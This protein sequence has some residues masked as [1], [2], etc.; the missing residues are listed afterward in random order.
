M[1]MYIVMH[2]Y[3]HLHVYENNQSLSPGERENW[4]TCR[5]NTILTIIHIHAQTHIRMHTHSSVQYLLCSLR[6]WIFLA[7]SPHRKTFSVLHCLCLFLP[8]VLVQLVR[9]YNTTR[10]VAVR[11]HHFLQWAELVNVLAELTSRYLTHT[12]PV[13][14]RDRQPLTLLLVS[15]CHLAQPRQPAVLAPPRL[16][17]AVP[18]VR[19]PVPQV[20]HPFAPTRLVRA[21]HMQFEHLPPQVE[22]RVSLEFFVLT[23]G[24]RFSLPLQPL[25]DLARQVVAAAACLVRLQEQVKRHGAEEVSRRILDKVVLLFGRGGPRSRRGGKVVRLASHFLRTAPV[26]EEKTPY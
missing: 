15:L 9:L 23:H 26:F 10:H 5:A 7:H 21:A 22:I 25:H 1:Y 11:A 19:L 20:A 6:L 24:A 13:G 14:A 18:Y 8:L 3:F 4:L 2:I 17:G 16:L 12:A